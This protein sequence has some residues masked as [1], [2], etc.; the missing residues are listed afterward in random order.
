MSVH[1]ESLEISKPADRSTEAPELEYRAVSH[2]SLS[3]FLAAIG[4]AILGMLLTLLI[5]ALINGGT[6]SFSGGERLAV[7]EATLERVNENVG[8][9]SAN[10]DLVSQQA[11]A[12]SDQLLAAEQALRA[13]MSNQDADIAGLNTAVTQ[14]DVTRQQFDLFMGALNQAMSEMQNVAPAD[15][16]EAEAAPAAPAAAQPAAAPTAAAP[17]SRGTELS[18]PTA[19]SSADVAAD[20]LSVVLFVDANGNGA[21]DEGET[22]VTGASVALHDAEGAAV[23]S[24]ASTSEGALF[25]DLSAGDYTVSVEDAAGYTLAGTTEADVTVAEDAEEGQILYIPVVAE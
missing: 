1:Q 20:A 13:E 6:L 16:A 18:I 10:V 15:V 21:F 24:E 5:L 4:G 9:V 25:S 7:F 22:Q 17:A 3:M 8:A 23:A 11:Q 2:D 14:L 19:V 12:V